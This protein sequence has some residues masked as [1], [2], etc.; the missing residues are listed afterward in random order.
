MRIW[1][2][3]PSA[4]ILMTSG[5]AVRVLDGAVPRLGLHAGSPLKGG[6]QMRLRGGVPGANENGTGYRSKQELMEELQVGCKCAV[7]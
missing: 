3:L 5:R 2:L 1:R 4:L 7:C 6:A